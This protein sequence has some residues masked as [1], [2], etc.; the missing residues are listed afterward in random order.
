MRYRPRHNIRNKYINDTKIE[1]KLESNDQGIAPGQFAVFY[2]DIYCIGG[3][4]IDLI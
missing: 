1:V 2:D 3:G 4:I